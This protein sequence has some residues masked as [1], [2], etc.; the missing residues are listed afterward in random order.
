MESSAPTKRLLTLREVS[1]T[2][3]LSIPAIRN[4]IYSGKLVCV[5]CSPRGRVLVDTRELES[6]IKRNTQSN[7]AREEVK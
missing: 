6:W 3:S 4:L 2:L 5:R 1:F 7:D